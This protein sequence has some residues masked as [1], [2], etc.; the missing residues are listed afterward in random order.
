VRSLDNVRVSKDGML[1][2]LINWKS[3]TIL[4]EFAQTNE[5][6]RF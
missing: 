4:N 6:E 1:L 5:G 2:K 3:V